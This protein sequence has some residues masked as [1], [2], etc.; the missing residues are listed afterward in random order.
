LSKFFI[1]KI[2]NYS[3]IF[4]RDSTNCVLA[5]V[6]KQFRTRDCREL[7]VY[8]SCESQPIIEASHNIKFGCLTLNYDKL[9]GKKN[10]SE[11]KIVISIDC[12]DQYKSAGISPWNNNWGN[13]HDFTTIPDGKNYSLLEKNDNVFKHL[14][15]PT[16]PSVGSLHI[17]D[18]PETSNT[19]YTYGEFYRIRNE[20]VR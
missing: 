13:I 19:P 7:Y 16:D 1:D 15:I 10:K 9:A 4:I 11:T 3:S 5:T 17:T 6:C 20:E 12:I 18:S 8:L 2:N 14:P